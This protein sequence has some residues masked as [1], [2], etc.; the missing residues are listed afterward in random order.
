MNKAAKI[1]V[2][3]TVTAM[4]A[5]GAYAAFNI[6][7]A[8]VGG[9]GD[10]SDTSSAANVDPTAMATKP[11]SN[12]DAQKLATAFLQTWQSGP[13][14][15]GGAA[16][17]TDFPTNALAA[18]QSY[19]DGLALTGIAFT[20]ITAA[21]PDPQLT[22]A[23][24]VNFTVTAQVKGGTWTYPGTL[25]VVQSASGGTQAVH[26]ASSVLYP[27]LTDGQNVTAGPIPNASG[28]SAT[29]LDDKGKPLTA[30]QFPSLADILNQLR[31]NGAGL[32]TGSSGSGVSVVDSAGSPAGITAT[33]FQ[34]PTGA[35]LKT[36]LDAGLQAAAERAVQDNHINGMPSGVVAIDHHT[37][38]IR[39]IAYSGS[40]DLAINDW[41]APGSTMKIITAATLMDQAGM[42]PDTPASCP[43]TTQVNGQLFHN[44]DN[45]HATGSDMRTA[46]E[47]SCNTAFIDLLDNAWGTHNQPHLD[48]VAN[49]A[50]DV[51]GIGSWHIGVASRD[52]QIQAAP[53]RNF[54]AGDAIG[55]GDDAASPLVMAS[56]AAT[57]AHGGFLQPILVPGLPQTPAPQ[58]MNPTTAQNLRDM[59]RDTAQ[60]GTAAPRTA[61]MSGVG[62]KT[63]TAEVGNSTNGWF[64]AFDDNIAVAAEVVGGST[65]VGSAG[66]VATDVLQ[67]DQ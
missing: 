58:Q 15:Y 8:V 50:T 61:G 54:L 41:S 49:E 22:G 4:L 34:A 51:F 39:A 19:H 1:A 14:H 11:P 6:V 62:A 12:T 23:T 24:K 17:D 9:G 48:S 21:G 47:M 43:P 18:L 2:A 28:G 44:V 38:E 60:Y 64:V 30:A 25:D 3:T 52:P 7:H 13:A 45:E 26:W 35:V 67:A 53:N 36:T 20:G 37:G 40:T 27:K 10:S 32:A 63:G 57:V 5:G 16:S 65:G 59:M 56:V 29:V 66:Y 31:A 55:Q 46:F 42:N 33:V